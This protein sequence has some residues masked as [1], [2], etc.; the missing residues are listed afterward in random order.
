MMAPMINFGA[1]LIREKR[2]IPLVS[3]HLYPMILPSAHNVPLFAPTARWLR[4]MPLWVRRGA[5]TLPKKPLD[6]HALTAVRESCA[7]HGVPKVFALS[8][9]WWHSPDGVLALFPEWFAA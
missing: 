4:K 8:G 2:R 5:M 7:A 3:V 1:R 9:Q 6:R